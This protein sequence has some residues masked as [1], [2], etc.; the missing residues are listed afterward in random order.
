MLMS[1]E[2]AGAPAAVSY[3][4]GEG[5]SGLAHFSRAFWE[6]GRSKLSGSTRNQKI[7]IEG[8][9]S[10]GLDAKTSAQR[11][12]AIYLRTPSLSSSTLRLTQRAAEIEELSR[13]S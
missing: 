7:S 2:I 4:H 3:R 9:S 12:V 1:G 13:R 10:K 8:D 5:R 11:W 6:V